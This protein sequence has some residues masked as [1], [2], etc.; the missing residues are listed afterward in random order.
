MTNIEAKTSSSGYNS[1]RKK[2]VLIEVK[3]LKQ[4]FNIKTS[5]GKKATVKAVDDVTFEIYK[6]ETLGLVGESGSG[7]TTL[8]RTILRIYEPT[9]GRVVFLGVDITKLGRDSSFPTGKN[10]VYFSRPLRIPRPSY[11]RFGYCG[12]ALDIHRLVSSKKRGGKSQRAVKN[13]RT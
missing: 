12:E 1:A 11:D 8:G 7:K 2:D 5:L 4:Y 10:A 6:G 3:N 9:A 13:G